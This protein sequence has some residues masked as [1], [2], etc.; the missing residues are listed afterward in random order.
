MEGEEK[1][2]IAIGAVMVLLG[3]MSVLLGL[4]I[5]DGAS[6]VGGLFIVACGMF[7]GMF[8]AIVIAL[9]AG[10]ARE[11]RYAWQAPPPQCPTCGMW[12]QWFPTYARWYCSRCGRYL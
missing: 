2:W 4:V 5:P 1:A 3:G 7:L 6:S 12:I 9:A 10:R 8:G 11:R